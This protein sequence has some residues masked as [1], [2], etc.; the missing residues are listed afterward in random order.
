MGLIAL[1]IIIFFQLERWPKYT[2]KPEYKAIVDQSLKQYKETDQDYRTFLCEYNYIGNYLNFDIKYDDS[3]K[4]Q[5]DSE[6]IPQVK[7]G[8]KYYYNPVTVSQYA[9]SLYNKYLNG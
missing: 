3:E 8:D 6:G 4:F 9:L 7:Y 1:F 2:I 5:F